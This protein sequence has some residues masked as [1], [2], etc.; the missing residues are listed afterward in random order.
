MRFVGEY[1]NLETVAAYIYQ[2]D[3]VTIDKQD[4]KAAP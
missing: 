3:V 2:K 4:R 1:F